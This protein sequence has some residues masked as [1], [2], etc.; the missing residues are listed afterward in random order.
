[1]KRTADEIIASFDR[2]MKGA[3]AVAE[4]EWEL[5]NIELNPSEA[6]IEATRVA[7]DLAA[8][9]GDAFAEAFKGDPEKDIEQAIAAAFQAVKDQKSINELVKQVGAVLPAELVSGIVSGLGTVD[10]I[11]ALTGLLDDPLMLLQLANSLGIRVMDEIWKGMNIP[12]FGTDPANPIV[13]RTVGP[14]VARAAGGPLAA[15]QL[16]MVGERGPELFMPR[17]AGTVIPNGAGGTTINV[18]VAGSVISERNLTDAIWRR[19][20]ENTIRGGSLELN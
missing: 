18:S 16:S 3:L 9:F 6:E 14:Q 20:R 4:F 7:A 5:Q 1:L 15:G 8:T 13:P 19:L 17:T 11:A 10:A 2:E 12:G